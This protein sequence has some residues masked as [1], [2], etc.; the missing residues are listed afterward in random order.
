MLFYYFYLSC[1]M[2]F[3]WLCVS[4]LLMWQY[5]VDWQLFGGGFCFYW[6][7]YLEEF[8][9]VDMFYGVFVWGLLICDLLLGSCDYVVF[10]FCYEVE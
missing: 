9:L 6:G 1:F 3:D 5:L 4:V 10:V 2:L 7:Y 8:N